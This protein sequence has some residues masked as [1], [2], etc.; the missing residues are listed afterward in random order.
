MD[1]A[2]KPADRRTD[3]TLAKP[4]RPTLAVPSPPPDVPDRPIQF[5]F[6]EGRWMPGVDPLAIGAKNF[7][8]QQNVRPRPTGPEG[9]QGYGKIN[10]TALSGYPAVRNGIQLTT[11]FSTAS[12]LILQAYNSGL[13]ASQLVQNVT[14]IP[15][16]GGFNELL[17]L[18]QA[19]GGA[20]WAAGDTVSGVT[21]GAMCTI[22][23][24]LTTLTYIVKDRDGT[25]TTGEPLTNGTVTAV[26]GASYPTVALSALHTD[27]AGA[28]LGRFA[29]WPN[30]QIAYCNGVESKVWAGDEM[31]P[32]AFLTSTAAVTGATLTNAKDYS[33][34]VTNSLQTADQVA[35][36][37]GGGGNDSYTKLLIQPN[38]LDG[39]TVIT[40]T[41]DI[42][43]SL[44]AQGGAAVD[45]DEAKYT[46][47]SITLDGTGDYISA[48]DH[49]CWNLGT[50]AFCIEGWFKFRTLPVTT[51]GVTVNGGLFSQYQDASNWMLCQLTS[52]TLYPGY[53]FLD[54]SIDVG[55]SVTNIV[56]GLSVGKLT[57]GVWYHFALKRGWGGNANTFAFT[58]SGKET[59]A[60]RTV[61]VTMPN[62]TGNFQVGRASG[63]GINNDFNGWVG[64][65]RVS[66]GTARDTSEFTPP[67]R[68][69][70][71]SA[72]TFLVG[73]T[74][75][76]QAV[77]LHVT[78]GRENTVTS[79]ITGKEFSGSSWTD[80][81]LTDGTSSGGIACAQSGSLSFASTVETS[82]AKYIESRLLYW[83]QFALSAG[84]TE[85]YE[86]TVD[87]PIQDVSDV[88]DGTGLLAPSVLFYDAGD[89]LYRDHTV[90]AADNSEDT[91]IALGGMT[92][93]D[94]LLLGFTVPM[95]AFRLHMSSDTTKVNDNHS[96]LT[97]AYGNGE[98]MASW[99]VCSAQT[100]G[101]LSGTLGSGSE[102]TLKQTGMLSF[103]PVTPGSE[104]QVSINGGP[105]LYYYKLTVDH[106]LS[107]TVNLYYIIGVPAP[108][109]F[110]KTYRFPFTFL[111]RPMLCG[112]MSSNEGNRVD[113]AMVDAPDVWNGP[114]SSFGVDNE[115][116]YF[117]GS[118]ADLT[119]ACEVYNRLGSSIYSFAIF[120]KAYETY[121]LNGYDPESFKIYPISSSQG[122]PAPLTMD[123]YQIGVTEDTASVRSIAMWISHTGPVMF[124]S[125]GLTPIPGVE[126]Y[127]DPNDTL[128]VNFSAIENARGW[129][130]PDH[131]EYNLLLPSGAGQTACNVWL[132]LNL[133]QQRWFAKVPSTTA[134]PYPQA[135]VRVQDA[136]DKRYVY[137]A[138]DN[139]HVMRLEYGP[140][141][142]GEPSAQIIET[143]DFLPTGN[144]WDITRLRSIKVWGTAPTGAI[145]HE[146]GSVMVT[147]DGETVITDVDKNSFTHYADGA[148]TGTT[149]SDIEVG[150][151]RWNYR[152]TQETNLV[153]WSHRLRFETTVATEARGMRL[154]GWGA[155][156]QVEREDRGE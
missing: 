36:I 127:F 39:S 47:A 83:Y 60:V 24:V 153:A 101:T 38:G 108:G 67:T 84:E 86:V 155:L 14:A 117:G 19:P 103:S 139:G 96:V 77:H 91:P 82:V 90:A 119:A 98:P 40:D 18:D 114:D 116:L 58:T 87:A 28:G 55:G 65:F 140:E 12:R 3:V 152:G 154:L 31:Y 78:P 100:D 44:T 16:A 88:W 49:A 66:V 73:S 46:G 105:A 54:F 141:W 17:T 95:M 48:P 102:K 125:G 148:T 59:H 134:D 85:I 27:A 69:W 53:Y 52:S 136:D 92:N 146:D 63:A 10:E 37:G 104:F 75:R 13:T 144:V 1:R 5:L 130:D 32:S 151:T 43:H 89:G 156:Y 131:P 93:T 8:V 57:T 149:L 132:V 20:G 137:G 29:R 22:V 4:P 147:E 68:A 42:G 45:T 35:T 2:G 138:R 56:S 64:E 71:T 25:F 23:T 111:N 6:S 81:T 142:D 62:L 113:Y 70:S 21:S 51:G 118:E 145:E 115:P 133:D 109:A 99:P 76:L 79:T 107:A 122:C 41:S 61:S 72:L 143:G 9:V 74:R 124:D 135:V 106:T 97:V 26:Q 30:N 150:A 50:D 34:Q 33:D 112:L 110:R 123:T 121:I 7:R 129:F 80:L 128:C 15:N 120:C 94:A 126:C 11:P